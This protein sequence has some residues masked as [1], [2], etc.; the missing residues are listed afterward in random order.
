M[1]ISRV[2][3]S[4]EAF[5]GAL[6][7]VSDA[8]VIRDPFSMLVGVTIPAVYHFIPL[9]K[10]WMKMAS[11]LLNLTRRQDYLMRNQFGWKSRSPTRQEKSLQTLCTLQG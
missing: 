6:G 3:Y 8:I 7:F 11:A 10:G 5:Q 9:N 1:I 2:D 4:I